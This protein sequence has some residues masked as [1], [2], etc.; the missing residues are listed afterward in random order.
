MKHSGRFRVASFFVVATALLAAGCQDA[1]QPVDT[2]TSAATTPSRSA[3]AVVGWTI[4]STPN[5]STSADEL[6]GVYAV[7]GNNVWGVGYQYGTTGTLTLIEHMVGATWSLTPS[8]NPGPPDQC[9]SGNVLYDVA[10]SS[11]IDIWAVGYY[12]SCSL[13]KPLA[14]RWN[15]T[16]WSV[17]TTPIPGG[18]NGN[19]ILYDVAVT[20]PTEA[21][22]VGYY[23]AS[24]G[25]PTPL[26][27][28]YNGTSW[29]QLRGAR[30]P[31]ATSN[32][33]YTVAVV[34]PNDVWAAGT[35][36]DYAN[37]LTEAMIQHWDG[38]TWTIV[39]CPSPGEYLTTEINQLVALSA[40]DVWAFGDYNDSE[41]G[42]ITLIEHWDG[43]A[44]TVVPSPNASLTYGSSNV[45]D[46]AVAVSPTDIWAVGHYRSNETSQQ[47]QT[48]TLHWDGTSWTIP[49]SPNK[50]KA[51]ALN[52][53]ASTPG[54]QWGVGTTSKYG[55]DQYTGAFIVPR[56]LA[57][58]RQPI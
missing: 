34:D 21:W 3:D 43:S 38:T 7:N 8:P 22:A 58:A 1:L 13:F 30:V 5:P 26:I 9:G 19:N 42:L 10:G 11:A 33:L 28:R 48:M 20:S 15:G 16:E 29:T 56:T 2:R 54:V 45:L 39:P 18:N 51:S 52:G 55:N 46:A 27:L 49:A 40:N 36:Y 6:Y 57:M 4:M 23:E 41:T 12:Y 25:A 14:M 17:V 35:Y 24:S 50:G 47:K 31:G 44:W 32:I 53:I 37:G